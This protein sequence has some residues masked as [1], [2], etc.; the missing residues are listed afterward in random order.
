[1]SAEFRILGVPNNNEEVSIDDRNTETFSELVS[2]GYANRVYFSVF[3]IA[4]I[5]NT[6]NVF[7]P[8][9]PWLTF[10]VGVCSIMFYVAYICTEMQEPNKRL[11]E[12]LLDGRMFFVFILTVGAFFSAWFWKSDEWW[13]PFVLG[14][15]WVFVGICT[16]VV[17]KFY[18]QSSSD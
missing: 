17:S 10:G 7:T 8:Q 11:R 4:V 9:N 1:M 14:W 15:V 16:F 12:W 2:E 3:V 13:V 6:V 18:N 5:V